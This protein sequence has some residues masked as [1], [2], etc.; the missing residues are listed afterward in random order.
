M[1]GLTPSS[2]VDSRKVFN[3]LIINKD[4]EWTEIKEDIDQGFSVPKE[5][6]F[7]VDYKNTDERFIADQIVRRRVLP[8]MRSAKVEPFNLC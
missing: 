5:P 2:E 1:G 4:F 3:A 7:Y 6:I 8:I